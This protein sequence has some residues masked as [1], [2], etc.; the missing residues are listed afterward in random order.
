MGKSKR[1]KIDYITNILKRFDLPIQNINQPVGHL[2]E[3]ERECIA[4]VEHYETYE[5]MM[6]DIRKANADLKSRLQGQQQELMETLLCPITQEVMMD[7]V[8]AADGHT[9]ERCA[10][11]MWLSNNDRSPLTNFPLPHKDLQTNWMIKALL[12][13]LKEEPKNP[14]RQ[15]HLRLLN[16]L[17]HVGTL[18]LQDTTARDRCRFSHSSSRPARVKKPCRA[19]QKS[20]NCKAG[21]SCRFPHSQQNKRL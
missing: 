16:L 11:E 7:P 20:R 14:Q 21:E 1:F 17:P 8:V 3:K 13:R 9:Y 5:K 18:V 10:I 15:Q 12:E 4:I 19:F 2:E 6:S